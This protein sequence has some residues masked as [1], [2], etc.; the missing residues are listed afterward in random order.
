MV[1][2]VEAKTAAYPVP[3]ASISGVPA[4]AGKTVYYIPLLAAI[5]TFA[6]AAQ[7]MKVGI[8][9]A[10][11]KLQVC[12][13]QATPNGA[14]SCVQQA[15]SAGAAGIV[16]DAIPYAMANNA[17]NAAQAKG[18]P[19][20]VGDQVPQPANTQNTDKVSYLPGAQDGPS[21]V[22]WW[23][24]ADSGGKAHEIFAQENDNPSAI[25]AAIAAENIV[26]NNC[27]GCTLTVK[28]ITAT[29][30][31]QAATAVSANI[32]ANPSAGYYFT[33]YEDSLA[34]TVQGARSSGKTGISL[35]VSAGTVYGLGLLKGNSAV[36]AVDV[37]D[38]A[39]EGWALTDEIL[40][41]AT[42]SA[43]VTETIPDRLFTGQNIGSIQV[44][45]AAQASGEWFGDSS[46]QAAFAKLWGV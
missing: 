9:R 18:I 17:L 46:Y 8:T 29:T 30:N 13:A 41:M 26:K 7:T 2:K 33:Q 34:P 15:V 38:E 25:A 31:A 11:L 27:S 35:A 23:V 36:K 39:Y 44:T 32:L 1:A 19:I 6:V 43:P 12:D 16:L 45:A 24:I 10:G 28:P 5:P 42:K 3:T 22:A 21:A 40:R 14:A 37:V 4:L 20:L